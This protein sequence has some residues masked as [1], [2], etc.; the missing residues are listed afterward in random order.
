[1]RLMEQAIGPQRSRYIYPAHSIAS[2]GGMIAYGSDWPV[3]SANPLE[4]LEVAITRTTHDGPDK[5]PLLTS[6]GVTLPEAVRSY[7][8]DVAYVNSLERKTGSI[9]AGKSAD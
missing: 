6:E 1:M 4:G 2:R 7:T 9:V 3:A 5:A 8:L